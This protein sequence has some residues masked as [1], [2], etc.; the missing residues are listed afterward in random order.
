MIQYI[1]IGVLVYM[2]FILFMI[3]LFQVISERPSEEVSREVL[4]KLAGERYRIVPNKSYRKKLIK[5]YME[6]GISKRK[7]AKSLGISRQWLYKFIEKE[8]LG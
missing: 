6:Q 3:R 2:L 5:E 1:I 8:G 7:M 4:E